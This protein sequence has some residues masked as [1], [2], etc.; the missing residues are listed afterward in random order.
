MGPIGVWNTEVPLYY[1]YFCCH[2]TFWQVSVLLIATCSVVY[3]FT[4]VG[5]ERPGLYYALV[6]RTLLKQY[7]C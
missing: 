7:I 2:F 3:L 6:M 4:S 5:V 1:Y